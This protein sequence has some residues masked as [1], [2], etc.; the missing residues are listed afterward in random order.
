MCQL[1]PNTAG[2]STRSTRMFAVPPSS[3][4]SS[5]APPGRRSIVALLPNHVPSPSAVVIAAQTF[6]GGWAI[7]TVRSMRS[8]NAMSTSTE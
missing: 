1:K 2:S 7:W 4:V 3:Q 8:G 5:A 6:S